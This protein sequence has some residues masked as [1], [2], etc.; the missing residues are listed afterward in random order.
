MNEGEIIEAL[1]FILYNLCYHHKDKDIPLNNRE[2]ELLTLD[3][4]DRK[5]RRCTYCTCLLWVKTNPTFSYSSILLEN[6]NY[7]DEYIFKYL[8][9]MLQQIEESGALKKFHSEDAS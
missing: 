3:D 8:M 4:D 7:S 9:G 2:L 6:R 1:G 5:I